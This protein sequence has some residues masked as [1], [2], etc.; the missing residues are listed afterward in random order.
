MISCFGFAQACQSSK[1]ALLLCAQ[2]CGAGYIKTGSGNTACTKCPPRSTSSTAG[3]KCLYVFSLSIF[4]PDVEACD[5]VR[6]L[7]LSGVYTP[8]RSVMSS[9]FMAVTEKVRLRYNDAFVHR[10]AIGYYMDAQ[11]TECVQCPLVPAPKTTF[12]IGAQNVDEY[13]LYLNKRKGG[14]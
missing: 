12:R 3:D 5:I 6:H 10:C 1:P 11:G 13:G 4:V 2:A 7:Y 14:L 8:T 9:D